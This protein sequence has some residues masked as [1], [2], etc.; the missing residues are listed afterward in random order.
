MAGPW[1]VFQDAAGRGGD[2]GFTLFTVAGSREPVRLTGGLHVI[3]DHAFA[4][5]PE[6][7]VVVVPAIRASPELHA[8]L[9]RVAP[10]VDVLMSVCTGAFQLAA[11]GLLDGLPAT[12]HHDFWDSFAGRHPQVLLRRGDRF[13][14][15]S[16]RLATAGGLTSGIDLALHIVERE[17]GAGIAEQVAREM[18]HDRR[19]PLHRGPR[20]ATSAAGM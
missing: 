16:P 18:E 20:A 5:A 15:A 13:V 9:R 11:A 3:P 6:P 14:E 1:E 2:G 7:D 19:G 8:W 10:R 12:T 17:L 4:D